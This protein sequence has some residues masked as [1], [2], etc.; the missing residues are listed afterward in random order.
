MKVPGVTG[1]PS[2]ALRIKKS[3]LPWSV[4]QPDAKGG[5]PLQNTSKVTEPY[6][7]SKLTT[8]RCIYKTVSHVD[9]ELIL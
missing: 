5:A 6:A 7:L 9:I 1:A 3:G 2:P 8:I 4:L